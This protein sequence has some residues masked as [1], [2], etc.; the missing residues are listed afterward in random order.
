MTKAEADEFLRGY[1]LAGAFGSAEPVII[2]GVTLDLSCELDAN[3]WRPSTP[4]GMYGR[5]DL[6]FAPRISFPWTPA[7][8]VARWKSE[9]DVVD[10]PAG[11]VIKVALI[12][13]LPMNPTFKDLDLAEHRERK[14]AYLWVFR[15]DGELRVAEPPLMLLAETATV[16]HIELDNYHRAYRGLVTKLERLLDVDDLESR[17]DGPQAD[18]PRPQEGL[19]T[20]Y[21]RALLALHQ[22][23]AGLDEHSYAIFGYLM[24]RAE[25]EHQLL[26]LA[27]REHQAAQNRAK[28]GSVR[29]SKSREKTEP[30]R[31]Q[32]KALI[33]KNH[34]ISLTACA[35]AVSIVIP[36]EPGWEM[37]D[38]PG[39]IAD[40]IRELFERREIN[41]K[42]EYR[43]KA[44]WTQ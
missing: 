42:V 24:G 10:A 18:W 22:A 31:D 2:D 5:A 23:V 36:S 7:E 27:L 30:L 43:P 35:K 19:S 29:R 39:W 26:D 17:L 15:P 1:Y 11:S 13:S 9:G 3:V 41:G 4:L 37:G 32:A 6:R 12:R 21:R 40:Q 34:N 14:M 20:T 33:R 8:V 25:A 16:A 44:E 38:D 28:G